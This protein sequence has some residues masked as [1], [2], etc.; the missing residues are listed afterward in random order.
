MKS[1]WFLLAF[2]PA[3]LQGQN[4]AGS[5]LPNSDTDRPQLR[6][7]NEADWPRIQTLPNGMVLVQTRPNWN[8]ALKQKPFDWQLTNTQPQPVL[9]LDTQ[10]RASTCVVP[11][12]VVPVNPNTDTKMPVL[13]PPRSKSESAGIVKGLPPCPD[14]SSK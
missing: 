8:Q 11:L 13:N 14:R 12:L 7:E 2:A 1:R 6:S 9:N 5:P 4:Q 3:L 10:P